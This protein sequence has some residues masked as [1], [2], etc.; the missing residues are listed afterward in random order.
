MLKFYH[1]R[2]V[3]LTGMVFL[4]CTIK[5]SPHAQN[6]IF[7]PYLNQTDKAELGA[8]F[9]FNEW[10]INKVSD[11]IEYIP[12]YPGRSLGFFYKM[13]Q[14]RGIFSGFGGLEGIFPLAW[15]ALDGSFLLW[16]KLHLGGQFELPF[17]TLRLNFLPSFWIWTEGGSLTA[18]GG[19]YQ[20]DLY[21]FSGLFHIPPKSN[22]NLWLGLRNSSSALGFVAGSEYSID[23]KSFI[24]FEYSFLR[25]APFSLLLSQDD[26]NSLEGSVH[27]F[28]L[29]VFKRIR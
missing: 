15:D 4:C 18:S 22:P 12:S 23:P 17:F 28:T 14:K 3:L 21:Q 19:M 10:V 5:M 2:I 16:I 24:R 7:N 8:G 11:S 13:Y 9:A 29:A 26:L 27:Y 6:E 25:R 20:F 1:F